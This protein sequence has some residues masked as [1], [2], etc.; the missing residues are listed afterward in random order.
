MKT[1]EPIFLLSSLESSVKCHCCDGESVILKEFIFQGIHILAKYNCSAC[2]SS[3]FHTLPIG[4]D[5]LF[6]TSFDEAGKRVK[7]EIQSEWLVRPLLDSIFNEKKIN[8]TIEKEV[9]RQAREAIVLNCIDNCFGH[10]FMKLWNIEILKSRYPDRSVIVFV[11]KRMRWLLPDDVDEV[12]SFDASFPE[13]E[14]FIVNLDE[15]VKKNLLPRFSHVFVSKAFTYLGLDKINLKAFLKTERFNLDKFNDAPPRITFVLREDRFWHR[16]PMEFFLFKLFV[17]LK[18][19][20]KIFIWRQNFLV[21]RAAR[22]IKAKLASAE[23]Y[24]TGLNRTGRLS[25]M[26][27]DLRVQTPSAQKERQWCDLYSKSHVVVGVHGSNMLIPTAL[28]GGFIEILPRYKI[29]HIAEDTL[30]DYN[31]RYTLFLGRYLDEFVSPAQ[32]SNHVTNMLTDFAYLH[33]NTQQLT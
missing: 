11:P 32:I 23:F 7:A 27:S 21:N 18:L 5:L 15:E 3:F 22:K 28:A 12:W 16:Y 8:I 31:S 1:S 19:D 14:K 4:H 29:R 26:I 9:F 20:K 33:R 10:S 17:K 25:S 13:L 2:A 24:A 6:P 30:I